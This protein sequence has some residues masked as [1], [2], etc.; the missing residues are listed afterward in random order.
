MTHGSD[1]VAIA[2]PLQQ[3]SYR[4]AEALEG[5][6]L[7]RRYY[8]TVYFRRERL[9]YRLLDRW[10][11]QGTAARMRRRVSH[12]FE[13]RVRQ[14]L[15]TLGVAYLL[16]IRIDHNKIVEPVLYS[17]LT[18]LFGL[19]VARD[20]GRDPGT[21]YVVMYD[22]AAFDCFVDLERNRPDV[23]RILDMSSA[24]AS[25]IREVLLHETRI[26]KAFRRSAQVKLRSYTRGRVRKYMREF[27][28]SH[29]ILVPSTFVLH[30]LEVVG[31]PREKMMLCPYGVDS[32]LW[33]FAGG[34]SRQRETGPM[35]FLFVGRVEAAKGIF[36]LLDAF[37]RFNPADCFLT[38]VGSIECPAQDL[39][40]YRSIVDF[41]GPLA[42]EE[43]ALAYQAADV[44]IM[45][46]LFEGLS[47]TILEA[48]SA[49]LPVIA[50]KA[51]AAD[52]MIVDGQQ[53][54][55]VDAG[56]TT[57][58]VNAIAWAIEHPQEML[59]MGERAAEV[60]SN[61]SWLTYAQSIQSAFQG[62]VS[63]S[64]PGDFN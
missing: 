48:M 1:A 50:S 4:L 30:S 17:L 40:P 55:L 34:E 42:R 14:I 49:A 21:R 63:P 11:P 57:G 61:H 32:S 39:E 43:V 28:L 45:P 29:Y 26:R 44:Y 15:D 18:R 3:H 12:V 25:L 38:V 8:T 2:H 6:G 16:V 52:E 60:A 64:A 9:L 35:R 13:P 20:I 51:S 19:C 37:L 24:P 36:Y 56:S 22:T 54:L 46:S 41:A 58:L 5:A 23:V 31:V 33:Q 27:D 47:L 10:L 53:G 62:I 59:V 7:L